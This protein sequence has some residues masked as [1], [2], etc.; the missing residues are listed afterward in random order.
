MRNVDG[1]PDFRG[2]SFKGLSAELRY[3]L[4]H[5]SAGQPIQI[6]AT[7]E[8]EWSTA[9]DSGQRSAGFAA[10][11]RAIADVASADRRLYGAVNLVFAPEGG[12]ILGQAWRNSAA[13]SAAAALSYRLTEP[14]M[15][16][17][18]ADYARAYG[19]VG[20]QIF[21]GQALYLGPTFHYQF[22]PKVDLSA[23]FLV[24][25]SVGRSDLDDFPRQMAKLRLEID[26]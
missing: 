3:V 23:A 17:L 24:Q 7:V 10:T 26:F 5:R 9:T 6:T 21:D 2:V 4:L 12:R 8:P 19:N 14:L 22:S 11:F 1:L 25:A 20:L 15:L 16:G 13:V 18:E